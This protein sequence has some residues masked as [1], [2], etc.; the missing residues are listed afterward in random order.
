MRKNFVE[1]YRFYKLLE[2]LNETPD[3][4]TSPVYY[5]KKIDDVELDIIDVFLYFIRDRKKENF[6]VCVFCKSKTNRLSSIS[7]IPIFQM[8]LDETIFCSAVFVDNITYLSDFLRFALGDCV[9]YTQKLSDA[10]SNFEIAR[11]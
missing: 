8:D 4:A 5:F 3:S 1:K 11:R 10:V 6:Q 9:E 2:D 7:S